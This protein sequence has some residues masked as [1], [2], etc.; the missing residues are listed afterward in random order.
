P[1]SWSG[2]VDQL[3]A[4]ISDGN[5]R[6]FF[7]SAGNTEPDQ[8]RRY[9]DSNDTDPVQDP[10]QAGNAGTVGA[11]TDRVLLDQQKFAGYVPLA[12]CG[13]LSPCSTTS[14]SWDRPWP[15]KPDIVLEGGNLV[16]RP[17]KSTVMD[18]DD[19]TILTTA[20]ATTGRLLVDFRDTSAA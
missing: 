11:Y 4:G 14:V 10:A 6:L 3:F 9:P 15:Y 19:M 5:P 16:I 12:P 7:I 17:D 13:D 20:H 1:S 2:V 8:R 18:P